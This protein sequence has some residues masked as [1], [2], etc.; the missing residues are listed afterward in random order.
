MGAA[1]HG[2]ISGNTSGAAN[3]IAAADTVD[4]TV[5]TALFL[6]CVDEVAVTMFADAVGL[7]GAFTLGPGGGVVL[8]YN[9][10]GWLV[11][12]KGSAWKMTLSSGV[13]VSGMYSAYKRKI[14]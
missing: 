6:N 5:V 1:V 12:P 8:P 2:V 10:D 7:S 13:Q 3:T 14:R 11:I 4:E 9:P